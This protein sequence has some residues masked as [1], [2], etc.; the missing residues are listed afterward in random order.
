[1]NG[2]PDPAVGIVQQYPDGAPVVLNT[3]A[4]QTNFSPTAM[5]YWTQ[6][7]L[8]MASL[9]ASAGVQPY[10]QFGEVQWWYNP[11]S[12]GMPFYDAYTQQQFQAKYGVPMQIIACKAAEPTEYPNEMAFLPSLI[13]NY[14]AGI[15]TVVLAQVPN[16]RFEVLYPTDTNLPRL[17]QVVNYASSDWTPE[18]LNCLKTESFIFTGSND[19]DSS[20]YSISVSASKGFPTTQRSHLVGIGSA[21]NAWGKEVDIAQSHGLESVVLFALDQYCLIG[22]AAPPFVNTTR[23]LRQG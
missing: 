17:N 20:T 22:Y 6:N 10:L 15:R 2:D 23:T 1:M 12:A 3:P 11:N 4:I 19:L 8:Q 14:T 9:Q 7:Y 18:N 21:W 5:T 16:C 13:G